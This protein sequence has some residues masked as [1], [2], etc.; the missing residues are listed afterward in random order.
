MW[1]GKSFCVH[2]ML[3]FDGVNGKSNLILMC[4]TA[5]SLVSFIK[6]LL[7]DSLDCLTIAL[8]TAPTFNFE[9]T[10]YFKKQIQHPEG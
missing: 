9:I 1:W 7:L 2:E 8:A 4:Y 5:N 3:K 6:L 10:S